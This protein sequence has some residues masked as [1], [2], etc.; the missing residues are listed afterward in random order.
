MSPT[1]DV[2]NSLNFDV[3]NRVQEL[4]ENYLMNIGT[5]TEELYREMKI[6][7]TKEQPFFL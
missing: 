1:V 5:G 7:L 4:Y 3:K 2:E 6:V